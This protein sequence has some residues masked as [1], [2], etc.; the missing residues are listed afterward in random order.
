MPIRLTILETE[1][2]SRIPIISFGNSITGKENVAFVTSR[3]ALEENKN[4]AIDFLH[5]RCIFG[6][7]MKTLRIK[8]NLQFKCREVWKSFILM[9]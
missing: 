3:Q 6:L 8:D 4:I 2:L 1:D 5:G 9:T 7:M